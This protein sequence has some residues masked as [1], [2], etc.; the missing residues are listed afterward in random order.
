MHVVGI[1]SLKD[2]KESLA[3]S[4]AAVLG[5][6]VY[7]ALSRLRAPGSGP[8]IVAV[9]AE[10]ERAVY[11][12]EKLRSTGFKALM[13]TGDEIENE[14]NALIVRRFSFGERGLG[15]TTEKGDSFDISFQNIDVILRGTDIFR[16]VTTETVKKRSLSLERAVLSGGMMISKTT[17]SVRETATEERQG[18]AN[19]YPADGTVLVFRENKLVYDSLGP[20]LRPSRVANFNNVVSELVRRCTGALYDAR[21]LNRAAQAALLGPSLRPE[22]HLIVATALLSKVFRDKRGDD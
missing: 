4:L 13:L 12:V 2:D 19:I 16:E 18:F 3:G 7:E 6:T 10:K 20:E 9:L 14:G 11:L 5:V 21:L 8:L 17:K 22:E 15:V 1:H